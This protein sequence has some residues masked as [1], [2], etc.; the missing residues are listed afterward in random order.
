MGY[1]TTTIRGLKS[2]NA[3]RSDKI[4][5]LIDGVAMN[6]EA[7]GS[8]SFYMDFPMQLV[9]KIEVL[10]GPGSTIYGAGAFYATVNIITKLG[11]SKEKNRLFIGTGSYSDFVNAS[12]L[13]KYGT[14]YEMQTDESMNDLTVGFKAQNKGFEFL[15]RYKQS[16]YGNFYGYSEKLDRIGNQ[17]KG[18]SSSYFS[19]QLSYETSFNDYKLETKAGYSRRTLDGKASI[20]PVSDIDTM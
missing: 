5:I 17:D 10:R 2:P 6:N 3:Y 13:A 7:Q 20:D 18:R 4:K 12:D 1:T 9:E 11:N 8:S 16:T 15:T 19:A 14:Q